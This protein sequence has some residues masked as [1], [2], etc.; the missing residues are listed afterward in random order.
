[1]HLVAKRSM[2]ALG[3]QWVLRFHRYAL[4]C[5]NATCAKACGG[6]RRGLAWRTLRTMLSRCLTLQACG[7]ILD[8]DAASLISA[9]RLRHARQQ[10]EPT[11]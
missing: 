6:G 10:V 2:P 5:V 7:H 1:M 8:L 3:A 9:N 4:H 11:Q